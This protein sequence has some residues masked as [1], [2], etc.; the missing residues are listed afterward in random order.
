MDMV[1]RSLAAILLAFAI[2][3]AS[4]QGLSISIGNTVAGQN[5]AVK[6]AQF[7]FR[8]NGCGDFSKAQVAAKAEGIVSVA[9]RSVPLDP[10]PVPSQPGVYA[11]ADQWGA[12]GTWVI[13]VS[14][15]CLGANAGAIVPVTAKGFVREST[16]LLS[17]EPSPAE[18]E[19]ALKAYA[20]PVS[21][22]R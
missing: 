15:S 10:R 16:Q 14:A 13:A 5:Y 4:A 18:I 2:P 12:D 6:T 22:P 11:I 20:S 7:I 9:R 8:V 19:T 21:V 3:L 1:I 17:H